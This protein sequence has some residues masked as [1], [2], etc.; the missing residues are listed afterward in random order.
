GAG[1]SVVGQSGQ[2]IFAEESASASGSILINGTDNVTGTG[3]TD[4][5]I[6][7]EILNAANNNN[8]T[9]SQ[10]GNISGGFDGIRA[11]TDGNGN[12]TV[13]TG[14]R[15][16]IN[17]SQLFGITAVSFGTGGLS[18]TTTTNDIVTSGSAGLVAQSDATSLP[19]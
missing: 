3:N 10:T 2:G 17:G 1:Q 4:S 12:V 15:L 9:V 18:V 8:I 5:G 13:T 19:Q 14:P 11:F 6:L 7:A 16:A